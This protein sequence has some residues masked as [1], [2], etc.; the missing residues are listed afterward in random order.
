MADSPSKGD[1]SGP[2]MVK[3]VTCNCMAF[4]ITESEEAFLKCFKNHSQ[5]QEKASKDT[6]RMFY[7]TIS[8]AI[9]AFK[10]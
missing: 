8:Q 9:G 10:V 1:A 3:K 7:V 2:T 5:I 6:H 4:T